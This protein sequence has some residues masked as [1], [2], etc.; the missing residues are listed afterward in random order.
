[1]SSKYKEDAYVQ[2][3]YYR[4][5]ALTDVRCEGMCGSHTTHTFKT[6]KD[7]QEFKENFCS[8]F[9]WNCPCFITLET[10]RG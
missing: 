10:D 9:Y 4:K 7:K 2:C 1:M 6:K 8:G 5:E 3:P